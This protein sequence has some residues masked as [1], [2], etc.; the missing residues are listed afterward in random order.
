MVIYGFPTG[1]ES[2]PGPYWSHIHRLS[3]SHKLQDLYKGGGQLQAYFKCPSPT[4]TNYLGA[5]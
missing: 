2:T 5:D 3:S 4:L 1:S